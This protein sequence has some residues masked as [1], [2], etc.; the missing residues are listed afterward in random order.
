MKKV[1]KLDF[2]DFTLLDDM[3][4]RADFYLIGSPV[5]FTIP[6]L[7]NGRSHDMCADLFGLLAKQCALDYHVEYKP[8][9]YSGG[10]VLRSFG[11]IL[12]LPFSSVY[13]DKLS[14]M[15]KLCRIYR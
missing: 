8:A 10:Y 15:Y 7:D 13:V 3:S 5:V 2:I 6:L 14:I 11:N 4:V 1:I 12:K 9:F